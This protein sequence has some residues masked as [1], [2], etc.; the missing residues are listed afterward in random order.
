MAIMEIGVIPLGTETASVSDYVV[1]ALRVLEAEEG[2]KYELTGMG[3]IIEGEV[4]RLLELAGRM[5]EAALAAGAPR[6]VTTIKIDDRR[7]RQSTTEQKKEVVRRK[8]GQ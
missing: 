7:D 3:T 2:L 5:H 8:L 1:A 4:P 6:M